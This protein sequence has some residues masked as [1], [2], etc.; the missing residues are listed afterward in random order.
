M[1][2]DFRIPV[3]KELTSNFESMSCVKISN[4]IFSSPMWKKK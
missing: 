4:K 3:K 2:H 1:I